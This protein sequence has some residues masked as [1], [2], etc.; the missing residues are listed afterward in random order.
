MEWFSDPQARAALATPAALAIVR[1]AIGFA[2][3]RETP[4]LR[5]HQP[6]APKR[7]R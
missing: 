7:R 4:K 2:L 5:L 1:L 3:M 6:T